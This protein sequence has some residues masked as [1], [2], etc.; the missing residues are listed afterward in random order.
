MRA[1]RPALVVGLVVSALAFAVLHGSAD[2]WLFGYS[3]VFAVSAG[4]RGVISG[5]V[6][7]GSRCTPPAT[8]CSSR[9]ARC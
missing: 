2:P 8:S 6:E 4:L 5:G 7:A 9:S 1:V 3:V